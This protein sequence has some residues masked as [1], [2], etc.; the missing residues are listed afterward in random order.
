M[1]GVIEQLRARKSVRA[2]TDEPVSAEEE[3]SILEAACQA[4][5]AGNQQLYS[6]IVVRDAA[7]KAALAKS[8]DHQ[9]FIAKAPLVLAFCADVRRW[10]R[11]FTAAGC[12]PREPGVGDFLLAMEDTMICAQNAVVAAES[13][14]IGSCYIGD[15]LE[16]CEEQAR[17]LGCPRWVLPV[18]VVVFGRPTE[19][20]MRRKKPMRWALEQVVFVDAYE[21][22]ADEGLVAQLAEKQADISAFCERKW[23]SGFSREMTRSAAR[24][25]EQFSREA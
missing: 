7:K 22:V 8:C 2:F 16:K 3:R 1:S 20:Q 14:G 23:N 17:I 24:I 19:A 9:P 13:L 12:A 21:D 5:T 15:I 11:G 10:Y 18:S 25:L 4:P 6:I